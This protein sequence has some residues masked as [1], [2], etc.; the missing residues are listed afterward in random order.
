MEIVNR[1][2]EIHH[3]YPWYGYR[4]IQ[5]VL[6][7]SGFIINHKKIQRLMKEMNMRSLYPQKHTKAVISSNKKY[8]YLLKG[9][10]INQPNQVWST[11]ITY[12]KLPAGFVYLFALIDWYSRYIVAHTLVNTMETEH[13]ITMI[14]RAIQQYGNPEICN[15]DQGSQ[16]TAEEWINCLNKNSIKVSHD[17]VGRYIDNIRIE[18]FW[19]TIKCENV[20]ISGYGSIKDAR[21]GIKEFIHYYNTQRPHQHLGYQ[22]PQEVYNLK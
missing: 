11:D 19:R 7:H 16:F 2:M 1:I 4:K 13:A 9:L 3:F 21:K 17:G 18:R 14:E 12:I 10:S 20:Y 5:A 22:T 6:A 8:P 15:T